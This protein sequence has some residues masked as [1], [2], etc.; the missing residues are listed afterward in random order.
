[1]V[2]L[3]LYILA[4][5]LTVSYTRRLTFYRLRGE[6]NLS[7]LRTVRDEDKIITNSMTLLGVRAISM[8][9]ILGWL[10]FPE[11]YIICMSM[12]IKNLVLLLTI[13]GAFLGYI[14]NLIRTSY[15]LKSLATYK[16]VVMFGSMWFMPFLRTKKISQLRFA[17]G[18]ET[19]KLFDKG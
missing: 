6:Y 11:P 4:T 1:M 14:F 2:A 8:G 7:A 9:A 17:K 3:I 15:K 19:E 18:A 12:V 13:V 16:Y 5:G 10:L